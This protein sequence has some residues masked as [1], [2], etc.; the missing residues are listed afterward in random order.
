[1]RVALHGARLPQHAP[2]VPLSRRDHARDKSRAR[3]NGAKA[4]EK[5]SHGHADAE[6]FAGH[7][8]RFFCG[9]RGWVGGVLGGVLFFCVTLG[10]DR[11]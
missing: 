8:C 11:N 10:C 2:H 1:M 5:F 3:V 7:A 6:A 4:V 9:G